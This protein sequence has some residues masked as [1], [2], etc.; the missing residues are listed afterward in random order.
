MDGYFEQ[1]DEQSQTALPECTSTQ[2]KIIKLII[3]SYIQTHTTKRMRLLL[4]EVQWSWPL[5][6]HRMLSKF[7]QSVDYYKPQFLHVCSRILRT[8]FRI[9]DL[10]FLPLFLQDLRYFIFT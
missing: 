2:F 7:S 4:H 1:I 3:Y 10:Y 8:S 9:L 5:V 6:M